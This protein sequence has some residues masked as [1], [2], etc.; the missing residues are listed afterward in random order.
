MTTDNILG[1]ELLEKGGDYLSQYGVLGMKWGVRK[2][3]RTRKPKKPD[4]PEYTESR[5][6][7][8]QRTRTLTNAEI[9][10]TNERLQLEKQLAQLKRDQAIINRGNTAIKGYLALAT[11]AGAVYTFTQTPFGKVLIAK[12]KEYITKL[13]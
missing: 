11:T 12:G 7:K 2:D 8:K 6:N 13:K 5:K 1:A 4:A 9:R 10:K 3:R